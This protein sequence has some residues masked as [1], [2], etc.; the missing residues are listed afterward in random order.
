MRILDPPAE[1]AARLEFDSSQ[2][3]AATRFAAGIRDL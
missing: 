1:P 2:F 3:L